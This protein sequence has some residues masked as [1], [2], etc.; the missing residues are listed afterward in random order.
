[1]TMC[2]NRVQTSHCETRAGSTQYRERAQR[3]ASLI[4]EPDESRHR[5]RDVTALFER[6]RL[7]RRQKSPLTD[8]DA[9]FGS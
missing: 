8:R 6:D 2:N 4:A 3:Y 9:L 7:V 1:M 5:G